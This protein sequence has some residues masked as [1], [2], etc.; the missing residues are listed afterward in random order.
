MN[1]TN[2]ARD[3]IKQVFKDKNVDNIR[4][5]FAGIS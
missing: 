4:V 3:F 1:I 2:D 5:F